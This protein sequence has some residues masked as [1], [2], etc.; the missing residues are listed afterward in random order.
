M[1]RRRL[2]V[3]FAFVLALSLLSR[4]SLHG[5]RA[6]RCSLDGARI[7]PIHRVDLVLDGRVSESFCCVRCAS[8]W[9]DVPAGA[10]WQVRD[11][12]SGRVI[13]AGKASFVRSPIVTVPARQ[14]R[15]HVFE[16]WADAMGHVA[17][18]GGERIANPLALRPGGAQTPPGGDEEQ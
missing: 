12:V 4:W 18:Y 1:K 17:E 2:V 8:E 6:E 9:P 5:R 14:D 7:V 3:W 13:D 11:E 15:T 10:S 16:R